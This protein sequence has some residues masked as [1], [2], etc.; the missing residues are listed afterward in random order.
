MKKYLTKGNYQIFLVLLIALQPIIE[1]DYLIYPML[2][3]VGLPRPS[4]IFRF[5]IIPLTIALGFLLFDRK[6]KKTL[7]VSFGYLAVLALYFVLHCLNVKG[8]HSGLYLPNHFYFEISDEF[9]YVFTMTIPYFLMYLFVKSDLKEEHMKWT[10]LISSAVISIPIFFGN[11]FVFGKS[12]YEGYTQLNFLSWFVDGTYDLYHPRTLAS[13]FFFEEG[14]TI[15]ILMFMVL[16]LLYYYF[17]KAS[18]KKEKI[19]IGSLI[20]VHSLAMIMLSTRVATYGALLAPAGFLFVYLFSSLMMKTDTLKKTALVLPVLMLVVCAVILP[21]SPAV[22]N[23]KIAAEHELIILEDDYLVDEGREGVEADLALAKTKSDPALIYQ[24]EAYGIRSNLMSYLPKA[25]FMDWYMYKHDAYFWL[26]LLFNVPFYERVNGRQIQ[27]LF[28]QY[29]WEETPHPDVDHML[30]LGYSHIMNGSMTLEQD[31]VQQFYSFGY[32]GWALIV[33]PWLLITAYGVFLVLKKFKKTFRTDIL[34]YA[35]SLC[36]GLASAY[37]SGH[38]LDEF[39]SNIFMAF[40]VGTLL[41]KLC[42]KEKV[43]ED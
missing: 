22:I 18:N 29:K 32:I 1:L 43:N 12:T 4:T 28:I 19:G 39:S 36:F 11:L 35:M 23:Q 27:S 40:L 41:I 25:Y 9:I 6:K 33:S 15:G 7:I 42:E 30:G 3:S 24:F 5:I 37:M 26:D 34:V 20:L 2:D 21:Y 14:N 31:F 17:S 13:K 8:I 10:A 16:P 38:T